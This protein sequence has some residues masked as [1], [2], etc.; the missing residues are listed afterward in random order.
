MRKKW[1]VMV[2]P[3]SPGSKVFS[4][5][6]TSEYLRKAIIIASSLI[7]LTAGLLVYAA[8]GWQ[9]SKLDR[10][11]TLEAELEVRE[12]EVSK[13]RKEFSVLEQ[14]EDKLRAMAGL[15]PR[16]GSDTQEPA[17]G[18]EDAA[19]EV[20]GGGPSGPEV[21]RKSVGSLTPRELL[22]NSIELKASLEET[23][24]V[25]DH[26]KDRLSRIPAINPVSSQ[27]AWISSGFGYRKDPISG[28]RRFHDGCDIVAPRSTPVI[29]P[30]DAVVTFAG[31]REGLGRTVE[32]EHG[33]GYKTIY[34]HNNK[35]FVKKG[36]RIK[37]GDLIAHVGSSGRSTG[38][39]LHYEVRLNGKLVN[40][41]K[42]VMQ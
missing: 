41:Y 22:A 11:S 7:V 31:W 15:K 17:G 42:Y 40:P 36:D 26:E 18:R 29:A 6:L 16:E 28:T 23:L 12:T 34:G 33:Y 8:Y 24:D 5:N 32:L 20:I 3:D 9:S 1:N 27:E 19:W 38:P 21:L 14:L 37:R 13:L 30:A 35:L 2:V 39:H 4:F 10:I 25:F